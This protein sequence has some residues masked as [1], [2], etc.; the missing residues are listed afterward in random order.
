VAATV[1][2]FVE[3]AGV[4]FIGYAPHAFVIDDSGVARSVRVNGKHML[5]EAVLSDRHRF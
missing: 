1:F 4:Y 3:A 5:V 2:A